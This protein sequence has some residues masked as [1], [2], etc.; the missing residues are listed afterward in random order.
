M[1]R[2]VK[3]AVVA[4]AQSMPRKLRMRA[5]GIEVL[6]EEIRLVSGAGYRVEAKVFRPEKGRVFPAV[7]LVPGTNDG[8][9]VFEGWSQPINAMELASE[10]WLVMSFDPSGRGESWGEEDYGGLEHQDNVRVALLH[11]AARGDVDVA[12][13]GVLSLSLGLGMACGALAR[14]P[15][16]PAKWLLDWEG[17]S[18]REIITSGGSIMSPAMGHSLQ[19]EVYWTPREAVR[20]VAQLR[21][22]YWRIQAMP[23]HAQAGDTRHAERMVL[24]AGKGAL[25][26]FQLN[27]HERDT[28]PSAPN[29]LPGGRLAANK[30][31]LAALQ[32]L[33]QQSF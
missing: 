21:C 31:L 4:R 27:H 15:E 19:D 9:K 25:P 23:D 17:P 12:R 13:L 33:Q 29:F 2:R 7:L 24:S 5:R 3:N 8:G 14:W 18:D 1:I 16:L 22:A 20:H 32:K 11:L 30:A 10:G 26:W 6:K 28:V